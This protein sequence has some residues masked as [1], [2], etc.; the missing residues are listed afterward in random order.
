MSANESSADLKQCQY[1]GEFVRREAI[2]CRYCGSR[3]AGRSG[4]S[5]WYHSRHDRMVAGVCG[6][7]AEEFGVPAALVRLGFVLAT[8]LMGG[9]GIVLY[10]VLWVV[11]PLEDVWDAESDVRYAGRRPYD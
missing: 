6:G 1:C 10:V 2:K 3:I 4:I 9:M 7:L 8:L 5:D 11:M